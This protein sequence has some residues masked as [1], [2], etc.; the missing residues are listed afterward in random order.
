MIR[1]KTNGNLNRVH[2][3]KYLHKYI[4]RIPV[5]RI[6]IGKLI[7]KYR[8]QNDISNWRVYDRYDRITYVP[9]RRH[10]WEIERIIVYGSAPPTI[11]R[12]FL[13][14]QTVTCPCIAFLFRDLPSTIY[15]YIYIYGE[16]GGAIRTRSRKNCIEAH[17]R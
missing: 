8:E 15:I 17:E 9:I 13:S 7:C 10:S 11:F 4:L 5:Q 14:R 16:R 6:L 1:L 12:S 2:V 3:Y